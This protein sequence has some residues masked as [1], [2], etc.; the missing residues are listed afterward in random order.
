MDAK[1]EIKTEATKTAKPQPK[2]T[3]DKN[4]EAQA[5]SLGDLT[6]VAILL[7]VVIVA[8]AIGAYVVSQVGA[9]LP[10]N[11]QAVNVTTNGTKA[12]GTFSN[13]FVIIVIVVVAAIIIGLLIR[14]FYGGGGGER[15]V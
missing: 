1:T 12:L 13:W 4:Y 7:V 3:K 8:V 9:Q 10:A 15:R 6:P 5:L 2:W 11:S 14:S